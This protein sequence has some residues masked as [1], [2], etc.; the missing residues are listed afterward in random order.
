M[1]QDMRGEGGEG[2]F[3]DITR[4]EMIIQTFSTMI[5]F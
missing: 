1:S 5:T 3:M 4:E 2:V